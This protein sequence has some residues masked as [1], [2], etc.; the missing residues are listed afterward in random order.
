M[1][2]A[3]INVE[4]RNSIKTIKDVCKYIK[5]GCDMSVFGLEKENRM[6]EINCYQTGRYVSTNEATWRIL[7]FPIHDRNLN[8]EDLLVHLENE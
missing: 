8:V 4:Y 5:K 1:F 7:E 6:D 2:N 3:H